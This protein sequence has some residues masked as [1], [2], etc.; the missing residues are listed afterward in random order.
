M[1]FFFSPFPGLL[2]LHATPVFPSHGQRGNIWID[3]IQWMLTLAEL[4]YSI[5][6]TR[7]HF[8]TIGFQVVC[9]L[10]YLS[11]LLFLTID[12]RLVSSLALFIKISC[13]LLVS[14]F[15]SNMVSDTKLS[16]R[17]TIYISVKTFTNI[18]PRDTYVHS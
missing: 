4:W 9:T 11:L 5:F 18:R 14:G 13:R 17:I 1:N 6:G 7:G 3:T 8:A 2:E 15:P 16:C 10:V 12:T